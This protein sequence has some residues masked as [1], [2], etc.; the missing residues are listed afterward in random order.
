MLAP[1]GGGA[2]SGGETLDE[3]A[4]H[5]DHREAAVLDLLHLEDSEVLGGGSNV[6]EV[7]GSTGV[8]GVEALEV[9]ALEL[10]L[11]GNKAGGSLGLAGAVALDGGEESNLDAREQDGVLEDL[12][13]ASLAIKEHLA[14]L[15][16]HATG[17]VER[18][19]DD[20][21]GDGKHGPASVDHLSRA[22][23]GNLA[24]NAEAEGVETVVTGEGTV[25]VRGH[26]GGGVEETGG[27][28]ELT[29]LACE[30]KK[31]KREKQKKMEGW[32]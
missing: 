9:R 29:V 26:V 5:G 4:E 17:D 18:L 1:V 6:E 12:G 32:G 3:H 28:V 30:K 10:T 24:V 19:G 15:G 20:N 21:A 25:E 27:E 13:A 31:K 23:L 14:G 2:L 8:D 16:P 7:E 11:E 22:V